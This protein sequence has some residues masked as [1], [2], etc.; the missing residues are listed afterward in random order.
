MYRIVRAIVSVAIVVSVMGCSEAGSGSGGLAPR[1]ATSMSTDVSHSFYLRQ[2]R[3]LE[4]QFHESGDYELE[5]MSIDIWVDDSLADHID[6][7]EHEETVF[8]LHPPEGLSLRLEG[9][10]SFSAENPLS[11]RNEDAPLDVSDYDNYR[12]F[13]PDGGLR[14]RYREEAGG[15]ILDRFD[16]DLDGDTDSIAGTWVLQRDGETVEEFVLSDAPQTMAD[17]RVIVPNPKLTLNGDEYLVGIEV[18]FDDLSTSA[19][20]SDYGVLDGLESF[21]VSLTQYSPD[22]ESERFSV[23]T[24]I[25]AGATISVPAA[26][27]WVIDDQEDGLVLQSLRMSARYS[28]FSHSFT[29]RE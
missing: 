7:V 14:Y 15:W 6:D 3:Y 8:S 29:I 23:Q 22:R 5:K 17:G 13:R 24:P 21:S 27:R 1:P 4:S 20:I 2:D 12:S 10:E 11:T 25:S 28:G 18:R 9:G 19:E 16:V 26:S